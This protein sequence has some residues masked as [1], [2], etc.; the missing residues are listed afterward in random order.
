LAPPGPTDAEQRHAD[1]ELAYALN[2]LLRRL[3]PEHETILRLRYHEEL[4]YGEI[5]NRLDVPIGTV[6]SRLS[7]A[8]AKL[9]ELANAEELPNASPIG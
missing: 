5:A 8:R 9:L 2:R 3:N 7:R 4:S 1:G 6:M